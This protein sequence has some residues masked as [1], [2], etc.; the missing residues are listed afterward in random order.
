VR[1]KPGFPAGS[2]VLVSTLKSFIDDHV[3]VYRSSIFLMATRRKG[4]LTI[5]N[6][7]QSCEQQT[8][9]LA[10]L[11]LRFRCLNPRMPKRMWQAQTAHFYPAIDND[12]FI[13]TG[14]SLRN[15]PGSRKTCCRM[16]LKRF[17]FRITL[18]SPHPRTTRNE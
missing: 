6:G 5:P 13:R 12:V 15:L 18:S 8:I 7:W 2:F 16:E 4:L 10:C 11:P 1:A 14:I 9:F 17:L 3:I